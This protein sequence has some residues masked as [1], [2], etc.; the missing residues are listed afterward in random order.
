MGL[1]PLQQFLTTKCKIFSLIDNDEEL[2]VNFVSKTY[3]AEPIIVKCR[4]N[5]TDK[6]V[7]ESDS[8]ET[9]N[10]VGVFYVPPTTIIKSNDKIEFN[11]EIFKVKVVKK[12]YDYPNANK[13]HCFKIYVEDGKN[14]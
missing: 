4:F 7:I 9:N 8:N 1:A 13:V 6:S 2:Q 10:I 12:Q 14:A 11:D 3:E 5:N